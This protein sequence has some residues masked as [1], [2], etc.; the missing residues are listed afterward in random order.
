MK[1]SLSGKITVGIVCLIAISLIIIVSMLDGSGNTSQEQI[2][3]P[4]TGDTEYSS[5]LQLPDSTFDISEYQTGILKNRTIIHVT[6]DDLAVFPA[7]AKILGS[8][9]TNARPWGVNGQRHAGSF[10]ENSTRFYDFNRAVCKNVSLDKCF[11]NPP[12]YEYNG[13]FFVI[14]SQYYGSHSTA[15]PT[16]TN[17]PVLPVASTPTRVT[18]TTITLYFNESG[19]QT[20][21]DESTPVPPVATTPTRI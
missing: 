14:F 12:L 10:K 7:L 19:N 3:H 5:G 9:D 11:T 4:D 17:T 8:A 18:N 20:Y 16:P 21:E 2:L 13:R 6:D 15:R 1:I